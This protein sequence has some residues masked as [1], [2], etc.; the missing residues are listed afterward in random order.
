MVG[1]G[2]VSG[3][4]ALDRRGFMGLVRVSYARFERMV[5]ITFSLGRASRE[6]ISAILL[7]LVGVVEGIRKD[8]VFS[9][10]LL[11]GEVFWLSGCDWDKVQLVVL[12]HLKLAIR[13][14]PQANQLQLYFLPFLR[15]LPQEVLFFFFTA[16]LPLH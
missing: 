6:W 9:V 5:R 11:L 8:V 7:G 12:S 15:R 13:Y 4:L 3:S 16:S 14:A 2:G 1:F 10:D